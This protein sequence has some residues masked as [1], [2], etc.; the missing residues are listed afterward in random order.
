MKR[1]L[2]LTS[3]RNLT[4]YK[5]LIL[6]EK[7]RLVTFLKTIWVSHIT[8]DIYLFIYSFRYS[9]FF[10]FLE[11]VLSNINQASF[12]YHD[13]SDLYL[14]CFFE[15]EMLEIEV[16]FATESRLAF[17]WGQKRGY[18]SALTVF[19]EQRLNETCLP[20]CYSPTCLFFISF[21]KVFWGATFKFLCF[22]TPFN[23]ILFSLS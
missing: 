21:I 22:T 18:L 9:I 10:F 4:R 11:I 1:N 17:C 7:Y 2:G 16:T 8:V 19:T 20:E 13:H 3:E 5:M 23:V 6:S 14:F 15:H 12:R